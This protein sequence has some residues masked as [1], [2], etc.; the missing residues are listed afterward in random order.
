MKKFVISSASYFPSSG[1][2]TILHKLCDTMN[3]LGYDAYIAP[4]GPSGLGFHSSDIPY[5][6]PYENVKLITQDVYENLDDAVVVYAETWYGNHLNAPNV[7]RWMMGSANPFYMSDWKDTDLWFW[8][9]PMYK[10]KLF[11]SFNKDLN[12]DLYLPEF[13]RDTFV[14]MGMERTLNC[15][16]LR[17]ATGKVSVNEY[18]H[19]P[20][21]IF[22]GDIGPEY[23]DYDY[24]GN[25]VNFA[26]LLNITK[27]FYSYDV[28]TF[29][30]IQAAM[31]GADSIVVPAPELDKETYFNGHE[32]HK[33]NAYGIDDIDRARAVRNELNDHINQIEADSIEQIHTFVEKC[34]AYFK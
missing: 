34:N 31:C 2:L 12:N 11:N 18:I 25:F 28:Y 30:S 24:A 17:K 26:K 4:S 21:D 29:A 13:Y 32:L 27:R 9:T 1:G 5:Y 8:Y 7:V 33:Y 16:T 19:D 15:W 20:D 22:L 10:T 23:S 14:N 6:T 3:R